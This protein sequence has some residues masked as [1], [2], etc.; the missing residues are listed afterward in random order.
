MFRWRF[1][2]CVYFVLCRHETNTQR[3]CVS[4]EGLA[5]DLNT[6]GKCNEELIIQ[7]LEPVFLNGSVDVSSAGQLAANV[8]LCHIVNAFMSDQ[9]PA[10]NFTPLSKPFLGICIWN[11]HPVPGAKK[12]KLQ[13]QQQKWEAFNTICCTLPLYSFTILT[14]SN[15]PRICDS[16]SYCFS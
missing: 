3:P 16:H 5:E 15:T 11:F 1:D 4:F 13:Q 10:A 6:S 2:F 7:S 9:L 12:V 8:I 14:V